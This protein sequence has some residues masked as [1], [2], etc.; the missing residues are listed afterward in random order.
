MN[1]QYRDISL[2]K[3]DSRH[4]F[5]WRFIVK[6]S[7][8]ATQTLGWFFRLINK[9]VESERSRTCPTPPPSWWPCPRGTWCTGFPVPCHCTSCSC[10]WPPPVR[11]C[12]AFRNTYLCTGPLGTLG[13]DRRCPQL[14]SSCTCCSRTAPRTWWLSSHWPS[15]CPFRSHRRSGLQRRR[16]RSCWTCWSCT[17]RFSMVS[18]W[19][20]ADCGS[21]RCLGRPLGESES[22]SQQF[23]HKQTGPSPP[24]PRQALTWG[25]GGR[26]CW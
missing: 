6:R 10:R 2:W 4:S 13:S 21:C 22:I 20:A 8:G 17:P 25:R 1:H 7:C 9:G 19:A 15:S 24:S 11:I 12:L 18:R 23:Q 3:N 5:Q 16:R 14:P 26:S